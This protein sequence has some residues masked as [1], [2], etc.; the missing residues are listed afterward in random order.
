MAATLRAPDPG[1]QDGMRLFHFALRT[2]YAASLSMAFAAQ[3]ASPL[4]AIVGA[5]LI[6]PDRDGS[7]A[8][9]VDA[10]VVIEGERIAAAG[11]SRSTPVPKGAKRIDARGKWVMPG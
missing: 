6:R 9:V 4:T 5:T 1:R 3:A 7:E 2:L 8:V 11:P 10:T